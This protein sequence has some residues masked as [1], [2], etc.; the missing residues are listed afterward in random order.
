MKSKLLC[1]L[2][3]TLSIHVA[4]AQPP[5]PGAAPILRVVQ[6][7]DDQKGMVYF[8]DV[9]IRHVEEQ[10]QYA[11]IVN[12]QEVRKFKTV[13]VPVMTQVTIAIDIGKSRVITTNGK[14]LPI[15][16]VWKRLKTN[17]VV[18]TSGNGDTPAQPFLQALSEQTLIIIPQLFAP[19]Q[20]PEPIPMP[21]R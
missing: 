21:K 15:D 12:G 8:S 18:A 17:T 19:P 5:V 4:Q 13:T 6:K 9:I 20:K 1:V 16:D 3:L 10:R 11:E 2:C 7:V 14:Q